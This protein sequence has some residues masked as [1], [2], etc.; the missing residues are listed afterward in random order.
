MKRNAL[1]RTL[2]AVLCA[3]MLLGASAAPLSVSAAD[4]ASAQVATIP[5]RQVNSD[6][7]W[8]DVLIDAIFYNIGF[9]GFILDPYQFT[10]INQKPVFQYIFGFNDIYDAFTWGV[11]VWADMI[12]CE[13]NYDGKDWRVQ[14]WKGGY[15]TFFA[16]G[17]EIGIYTKP[18]SREIE[19]YGAAA[20]EDWLYLTYTMY[21]RGQ[22]LYTRPSPYLISDK[23]P[24][25][26]APGYKILSICT[27]FMS[28]PRTN[29][30][31][32]ATIEFK[33]NEMALLF[34]GCMKEKGFEALGN[35]VT[36]GLDT[37]ETYVLLADE[38]SVR[39]IWQNVN[40]GWF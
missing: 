37:P 6:P 25:W 9:I 39:F 16:T 19:H 15:G 12:K 26:W 18:E 24:Y 31:M 33:D 5:A 3:A 35:G 7:Q 21:N 4:N 23:G 20:R 29:V 14:F 10:I 8:Y 36:M 1:T 13:F 22:E 17:G 11:N 28:S 38:K 40:E 27:D 2:C 32:D 30:V 34:I